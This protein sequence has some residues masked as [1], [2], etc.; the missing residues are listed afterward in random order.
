M[1][2]K[3]GFHYWGSGGNVTLPQVKLNESTN[4]DSTMADKVRAYGEENMEM[5]Q[6]WG[7][8]LG[9]YDNQQNNHTV[10]YN[11]S[12]DAQTTLGSAAR[13]KGHTGQSSGQC[14]S[15]AAT[16]TSAAIV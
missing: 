9:Q 5:G 10:K 8:L 4:T 1:P 11:Y 13:P 15:A 7:Y 2:T 12:T 16:V 3:Y 14:F 6:D